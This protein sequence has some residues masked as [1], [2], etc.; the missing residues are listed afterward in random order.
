MLEL[1]MAFHSVMKKIWENGR[2]IEFAT[3]FISQ[4]LCDCISHMGECLGLYPS[5][6]A[7]CLYIFIYE[8][9]KFR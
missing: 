1:Y 4:M 3:F 5:G 8:I 2:Q 7:P 9:H 6:V